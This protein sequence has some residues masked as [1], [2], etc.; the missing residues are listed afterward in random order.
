MKIYLEGMGIEEASTVHDICSACHGVDSVD[1]W[2]M[3]TGYDVRIDTPCFMMNNLGNNI[4]VVVGS[5]TDT[6]SFALNYLDYETM[7]II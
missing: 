4:F 1:M 2:E 5:V 7:K 3:S 6:T